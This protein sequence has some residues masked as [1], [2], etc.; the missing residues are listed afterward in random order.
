MKFFTLILIFVCANAVCAGADEQQPNAAQILPGSTNVVPLK[1]S[2]PIY[3]D[4]AIQR[5]IEGWVM[6]RFVVKADGTTDEIEVVDSS[7]EGY[8][9]DA[10][11]KAASNRVYQ[12][13]T[14][15]G[16][17]VMQG[18]IL[19]R[20]VF[21]M[22]ES[23]GRVGRSFLNTYE[24]ASKALDDHDLDLAKSLIDKLDAEEKRK[25]AEVCYLDM[26]KARY[27]SLTGDKKETLRYVERALVV[28]DNSA[29]TPIYINLLKQAVVDNG[30]AKNYQISLKRF[31]T[32]LQVDKDL[33]A[34][35]PVREYVNRVN[36][37][38]NSDAPIQSMR[39]ISDSC[40]S[41]EDENGFWW[42]ALNRN[43]FYIDQVDGQLNDIMIVCENSTVSFDFSPETVWAVNKEGQD[44][45][46]KVSGDKKTTFRLVELANGS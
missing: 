16:Q 35:D 46:L 23:D 42:H 38:L 39:E 12:P 5:G 26:L 1:V 8:F 4:A 24:D 18:N 43:Q 32:L 34:D 22:R 37:L 2:D 11:I 15:N 45:S 41:C 30:R 21:M 44:C 36:L 14:L 9:E 31:E 10:A 17:A 25:L 33:A 28:A 3:P 19:L 40:E 27:F 7:V 6:V 20:S 13:A 29:S